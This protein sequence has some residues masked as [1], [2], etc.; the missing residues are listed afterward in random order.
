MVEH[1]PSHATYL[2]LCEQEGG[3]SSLARQIRGST[4]PVNELRAS[5]LRA[6]LNRWEQT[7]LATIEGLRRQQLRQGD[8][9]TA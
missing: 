1:T 8:V 7:R 9:A 2:R 5:R 6:E 4:H 3:I